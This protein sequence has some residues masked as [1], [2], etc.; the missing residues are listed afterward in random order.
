VAD[1]AVAD[2]AV[3]D[4]AVA[5]EVATADVAA[6]ADEAADGIRTILVTRSTIRISIAG[7]LKF[8]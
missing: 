5:D 6:T 8:L 7:N 2:E 4:E 3:A 1:E